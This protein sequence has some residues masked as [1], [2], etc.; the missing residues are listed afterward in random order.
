LP[1][2]IY[3]GSLQGGFKMKTTAQLLSGIK[4][5]DYLSLARGLTLVENELPGSTEIL[6]A[7]QIN[8]DIPVIG[9]TGPPGAGKSTLLNAMI[10][11][12]TAQGKKVAVL[13][14]DPTSPFNLGSL[15]GDRIRM[16]AHFNNPDIYIRS[17]ATRGSLGG[18]AGKIIEMT[19]ILRSSN[20]DYI[21]IETVGVGQSEIEI[22]GLADITMIVLVPE[23]GDEIQHIKSGLMEIGNVFIVNKA[24]RDGAESFANRLRK[25]LHSRAD[26]IPVFTTVADKNVGTDKIMQWLDT[27]DIKTNE[28]RLF[29]YAEKAYKLIQHKRML[30]LSKTN[31]QLHLSATYLHT[32]FNL[33]RFIEQYDH[34]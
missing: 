32:D 30:D 12:W 10:G 11:I 4:E 18:L 2:Q 31:L 23:S 20:F 15:L 14:V 21:L 22:A 5:G 8:H 25:S 9:I 19:D 27:S 24:D 17:V 16:S 34:K 3:S 33:Y 6:Q 1:E 29:L 26:L 13:A 7:L 28:R